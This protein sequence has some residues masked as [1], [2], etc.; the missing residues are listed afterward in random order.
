MSRLARGSGGF[1]ISLLPPRCRFAVTPPLPSGWR[2]PAGLAPASISCNS[3]RPPSRYRAGWMGRGVAGG[4]AIALHLQQTSPGRVVSAALALFG[5]TQADLDPHSTGPHSW[6]RR[7]PGAGA[8]QSRRP[9]G[10]ALPDGRGR[11]LMQQEGLVTI[12]LAY[13]AREQLFHTRNP[14]AYGGVYED[15]LPAPPP[16]PLPVTCGIC[17]GLTAASSIS[18]KGRY[19][20]GV[21]PACRD[22]PARQLNPG[23][24]P[25]PPDVIARQ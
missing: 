1:A 16:R 2:W 25:R 3:I 22:P 19:G 24:W 14:F 4:A 11:T 10:H 13:A 5:Y 20:D 9:G 21:A 15:P 18:F 23:I 7:S 17:T 8:Q 6:W 12:L